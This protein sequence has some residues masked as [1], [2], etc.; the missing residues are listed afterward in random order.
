[1]APLS[2]STLACEFAAAVVYGLILD[3]IKIPITPRQ[4]LA[5]PMIQAQPTEIKHVDFIRDELLHENCSV[6]C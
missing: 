4:V 2:L 5:S 1:M 6:S 3:G